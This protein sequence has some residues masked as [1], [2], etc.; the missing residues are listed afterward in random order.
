MSSYGFR[1]LCLSSLMAMYF[2]DSMFYEFYVILDAVDGFYV[3]LY[4]ARLCCY[5]TKLLYGFH[6]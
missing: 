4:H 6:G 1:R 3:R 2:L 5:C